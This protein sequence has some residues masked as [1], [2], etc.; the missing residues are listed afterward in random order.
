M[1]AR[2]PTFSSVVAVA[3]IATTAVACAGRTEG[4]MHAAPVPA[5]SSTRAASAAPMPV[6]HPFGD[7]TGPAHDARRA[8]L[9][10][11][12]AERAIK[13][14]E[15]PPGRSE[16]YG[17][18]TVLVDAPIDV[19]EKRVLDFGKYKT[20]APTRFRVSRVTDRTPLGTNVYM[21]LPILDGLVTLWAESRFSWATPA[22]ADERW[23]ESTLLRGNLKSLHAVWTM[24]KVDAA[25]TELEIDLSLVPHVPVP[26][27]ASDEEL[28]DAAEKAVLGIA[29]RR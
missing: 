6:R 27:D 16:R 2:S 19:V 25:R 20:F 22:G 24:W 7:D 15:V 8:D 12:G 23:I 4:A 14:N 21:Q 11:R 13:W 5:G 9:L 28:R 29:T 17:R 18:A 10:A 26:A 1:K 3:V